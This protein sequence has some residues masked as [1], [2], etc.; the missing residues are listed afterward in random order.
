MMWVCHLANRL[1]GSY[2]VMTS[3]NLATSGDI[4]WHRSRRDT[5]DTNLKGQCLKCRIGMGEIS[6]RILKCEQV[7]YNPIIV[8]C[9][10]QKLPRYKHG[11]MC[12]DA[13]KRKMKQTLKERIRYPNRGWGP[14]GTFFWRT[15][16]H[17]RRFVAPLLCREID[18]LSTIAL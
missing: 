10:F 15:C 9:R 1:M 18:A 8:R 4:C 11:R 5:T 16:G 13:V 14:V 7:G 12:V 6:W 17:V 3:K 2:G